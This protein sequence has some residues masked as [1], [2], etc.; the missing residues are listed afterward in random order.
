MEVEGKQVAV[1]GGAGG[2]GG[3]VAADLAE[4]GAVVYSLDLPQAL[5]RA[6]RAAVHGVPVDIS[7]EV[8]VVRAFRE[9]EAATGGLDALV[10]ASGI[11]LH[12]RDGRIGDVSREVWEETQR[13]NL[14]GTFLAV[15][16]AIRLMVRRDR[17]SLVLIGS[18]TGLTMSG[19][20]YSAYAASKAGMMGL[21]RIVAADYAS[22][23]VRANVVVPGTM[24]T[25]LIEP[26]LADPARRDEL[27]AGLPIGRLGEPDDLVGIVRWLV[28][29][30][31]GF[32]TGGFFPVD[33][34]LTAR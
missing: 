21:A 14:T 25:P 31:S 6:G 16:H 13:V 12:G 33:G 7:D 29:D 27:L 28:S 4:A 32:A 22:D 26:L 2:L 24:R 34:G 5:D 15:K 8:E 3:A 9:V 19:S 1:T 17:S 11:Q 23:G 30:A 18:P 20:G 10:V